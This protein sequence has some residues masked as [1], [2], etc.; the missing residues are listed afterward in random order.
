VTHRVKPPLVLVLVLVRLDIH[1]SRA[2]SWSLA[3]AHSLSPLLS[4]IQQS[5]TTAT[6]WVSFAAPAP[7]P[8]PSTPSTPQSTHPRTPNP[9]ATFESGVTRSHVFAPSTGLAG[10]NRHWTMAI[11]HARRTLR[12]VEPSL[13]LDPHPQAPRPIT[14]ERVQSVCVCMHVA[15]ATS[16]LVKNPHWACDCCCHT[17]ER[18][19][20]WY[21]LPPRS[22]VLAELRLVSSFSSV[23]THIHTL[24][25]T[26][27][28]LLLV[29]PLALAL[30]LSHLASRTAF[31]LASPRRQGTVCA[32]SARSQTAF[33]VSSLEFSQIAKQDFPEYSLS[34]DSFDLGWYKS[35]TS[36][37]V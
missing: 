26:P 32:D 34:A 18:P 3:I 25:P 6:D 24:A 4:T 2:L 1:L 9:N 22:T 21:A 7:V 31:L 8:Y 20:V 12:T 33:A 11:Q 37:S 17:I 15:S 29:F 35:Q 28:P 5:T 13:A 36:S 23:I 10:W 30:A 27:R 14:S 19:P 16:Y